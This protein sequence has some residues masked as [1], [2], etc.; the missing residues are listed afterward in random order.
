MPCEPVGILPGSMDFF[1]IKKKSKSFFSL[2]YCG[3]HD[4]AT[5]ASCISINPS[6]KQAQE[7]EEFL[8]I[9]CVSCGG[10]WSL[11]CDWLPCTGFG[12]PVEVGSEASVLSEM[13]HGHN[14]PD[15]LQRGPTRACHALFPDHTPRWQRHSSCADTQVKQRWCTNLGTHTTA[16]TNPSNPLS[17]GGVRFVSANTPLDPAALGKPVLLRDL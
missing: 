10:R 8:R 14:P 6:L 2:L 11:H 12:H 13:P 17:I 16:Y 4:L 7:C 3:V 1:K 5:Y 9:T 15:H